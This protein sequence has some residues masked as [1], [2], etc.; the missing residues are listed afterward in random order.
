MAKEHL[1][2]DDSIAD[3][4]AYAEA[5]EAPTQRM[6]AAFR[7]DDDLAVVLRMHLE[8]ESAL[9]SRLDEAFL[10]KDAINWDKPNAPQFLIRAKFAFAL[11]I[12]DKSGYNFAK[13]LALLRNEF[14]HRINRQLVERDI[15]ELVAQRPPERRAID[16][17]SLAKFPLQRQRLVHLVAKQVY[18]LYGARFREKYSSN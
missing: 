4:V 7:V 13:Q 14:G 5:T 17:A 1:P 9:V 6:L 2:L 10:N 3:F 15:D 16:M 18:S 12:I 11:G 8:L